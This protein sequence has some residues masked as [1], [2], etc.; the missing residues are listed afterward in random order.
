MQPQRDSP[1][2]NWLRH[3]PGWIAREWIIRVRWQDWHL[4]GIST[5]GGTN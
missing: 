1:A 5:S 3:A 2:F 4:V